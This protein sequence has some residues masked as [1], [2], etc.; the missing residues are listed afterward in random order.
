[1]AV[2]VNF[3]QSSDTGAPTVS[4]TAGHLINVL[5]ACL[6]N[7]YNS[8]TITITRSGATATASCTSHGFN[9]YETIL[10]SGANEA[11]YNGTFR[12][13]NITANT[14]DFTVTGS[15]TTPA[16]GTITAKVNPAG[17]T[18]PFS[19]TNKAAYRS[20]GG[21]RLYYRISD[22]GTGSQ[23]Y[24][25]M[26]GYETMTTVDA[27]TGVFLPT[28]ILADGWYI[29]KSSAVSGATRDWKIL[30]TDK[31]CFLWINQSTILTASGSF[32]FGDFTSVKSGD[33]Y[34]SITFG[35]TGTGYTSN[36]W[37]DF[38]QYSTL[39]AP[40]NILGYAGSIGI[41]K[42]GFSALATGFDYSCAFPD[43]I[44]S[45]NM[46]LSPIWLGEYT[47]SLYT[48]RGNLPGIWYVPVAAAIQPTHGDTFTGI[49]L[50]GTN[51]VGKTFMILTAGHF[52]ILIL[53][54][55][56]MN[57]FDLVFLRT[58]IM[59][60]EN[61]RQA[62]LITKTT[63]CL[64][65]LTAGQMLPTILNIPGKPTWQMPSIITNFR[66]NFS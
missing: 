48:V 59:K 62:H 60:K 58:L 43:P 12:I 25:R 15:P 2:K 55:A 37:D 18:K 42:H 33:P 39:Y 65:F 46:P 66:M 1:M 13:T 14:F 36:N 34:D 38:A 47:N 30:A 23:A 61:C 16:T 51:L 40:R 3:Y 5:D 31:F 21:N 19:G 26:V 22:D 9:S 49:D 29:L 52:R 24:A 64:I 44:A 28:S 35:N 17:W 45:G 56:K 8:Q 7:G 20:D 32:V 4:G 57:N 27:G 6:I 54:T 50:Y 53:T 11:E 63:G 10:I 41:A